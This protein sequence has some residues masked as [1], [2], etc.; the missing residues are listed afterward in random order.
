MCRALWVFPL[1]PQWR[2]GLCF[3]CESRAESRDHMAM[4]A[5]NSASTSSPSVLEGRRLMSERQA[6]LQGGR[7]GDYAKHQ[8]QG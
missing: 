2:F 4:I 3:S 8:L 7:D 5:R 6:K 1:P